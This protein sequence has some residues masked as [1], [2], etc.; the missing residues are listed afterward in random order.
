MH[1]APD[2]TAADLAGALLSSPP[3]QTSILQAATVH[4]DYRNMGLMRLMIRHWLEY[5]QSYGKTHVHAEIEVRNAASWNGFLKAGLN[6]V[7]VGRS[8]IDGAQVYSA[9]E[10]IKYAM[11]R[12]LEPSKMCDTTA[13]ECSAKD[14]DTQKKYME[15]GYV[16]TDLQEDRQ[17]LVMKKPLT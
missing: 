10:R 14:I 15:A 11:M 5:A 8:P 17:N 12:Q 13:L 1:P 4:P 16:V 3:G 9:E 6:I 7:K 2:A